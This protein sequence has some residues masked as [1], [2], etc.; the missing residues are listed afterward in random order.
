MKQ[1][2][3]A[4]F[5][6]QLGFEERDPSHE[7]LHPVATEYERRESIVMSASRRWLAQPSLGT[8][9]QNARNP[10][11]ASIFKLFQITGGELESQKDRL[12]IGVSKPLS[13]T[14]KQQPPSA[15]EGLVKKCVQVT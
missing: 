4:H 2:L 8:I 14:L 3:T 9:A 5:G 10:F 6:S 13:E 7:I 12:E 11:L 15:L 1:V